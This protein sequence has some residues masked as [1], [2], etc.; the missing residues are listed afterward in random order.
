MATN[1]ISDNTEAYFVIST[2]QQAF[3]T[4]LMHFAGERRQ[5][6]DMSCAELFILRARD[7]GPVHFVE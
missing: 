2:G 7:H 5:L 3:P 6:H 1:I 4:D